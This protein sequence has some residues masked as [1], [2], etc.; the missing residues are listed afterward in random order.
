VREAPRLGQY[1]LETKIGEGGMA[2]VF[3]ARHALLKRPN[4]VKILKRH[5]ANDEVI[6]R[7]EREVQLASRLSH[8]N[9]VEIYDYG[10]TRGGDFYYVME[11]LEGVSLAELVAAHGAVPPARAVYILRQICAALREVHDQG[12]VHRD[13]KPDNIMLCRRG[14]EYDV[15]KVLD[16]GIV[17]NIDHPQTRD[18]TRFVHVLGAPLYMAP[19]RLANPADV[20]A[21]SDIYSVGAVGYYLLA[22][23]AL[24]EHTTDAELAQQI[25]YA[26]PQP[27][28]AHAPQPLPREF[29]ELIVK[30]LAKARGERPQS[31]AELL[32]ALDQLATGLP[33]SSGAA[34]SWWRERGP[35]LTAKSR[36]A[37]D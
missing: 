1:T 27:P 10:R 2:T 32:S 19:E 30:C 23:R 17:K 6:A 14:G 24:F 8:P 7:F 15:V 35:A 20:D 18:I 36:P 28:S 9:T 37:A 31:V 25:R 11:Y 21:R 4:A 33:W 29:D 34:E 22:G 5:L 26:P 12:L 16:F 3:L 13:I